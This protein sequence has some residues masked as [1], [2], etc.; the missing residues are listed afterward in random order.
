MIE[1]YEFQLFSKYL[2]LVSGTNRQLC[3]SPNT[4]VTLR[5]TVGD[6]TF[7]R[8]GELDQ[9]LRALDLSPFGSWEI[10]RVYS[11]V[12][13]AR[14]KLFMLKIPLTHIAGEEC[15]T[16]YDESST[17]EDC[18]IGSRQMGPLRVA[19][20]RL[21]RVRDIIR[22]WGGELIAS[23]RLAD[24]MQTFRVSGAVLNS[25]IDSTYK[26]VVPMNL[27]RIP[28]GRELVSRATERGVGLSGWQFFRWVHQEFQRSLW[29]KVLGEW[30]QYTEE[31]KNG[32]NSEDTEI[33]KRKENTIVKQNFRQIIVISRPIELAESS[34][35]GSNPFDMSAK[36][37]CRCAAGEIAGARPISSLVVK[38]A[39]WDGS[40]VCQTMVYMGSRG[41]LFRP[42]QIL[43]VSKRFFQILRQQE[44]KGFDFEVV[45]TI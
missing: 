42:F 45:D 11:T 14:A 37:S 15:G 4:A 17:C 30:K 28:S 24:L 18:G 2:P 31:Q 16:L 41:G 29:D 13:I 32:V 9:Q 1:K 39:S 5:G 44:M 43:V 25:V 6:S 3:E 38:L 23:E 22:L 35:F 21:S 7:V 8:I 26:T 10:K 19:F 36:G 20:R 34:H 12:E 40:D 27:S 33:R